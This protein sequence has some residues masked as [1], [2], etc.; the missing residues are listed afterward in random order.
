MKSYFASIVPSKSG[1]YVCYFLDFPEA[2]TQGKDLE[3]AVL[4]AED[5]LSIWAEDYEPVGKKK[6]PIP[7]SIT[8]V[9]EFTLLK[10]ED[11]K[12]YYDFTREPIYQFIKLPNLNT[13]PVRIQIS[14]P[15][16]VLE[17]IDK[18]A[19]SFGMTRSGFLANAA[20]SFEG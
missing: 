5:V 11:D 4:M 8:Q 3:D 20:M 18:K 10:M 17:K 19:A 6:L 1:A 15:A 13:K 16:N 12:Q 2:F 14:M 9:K 7:S